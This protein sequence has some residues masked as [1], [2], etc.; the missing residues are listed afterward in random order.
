MVGS[1]VIVMVLSTPLV[2]QYWGPV[3]RL[4]DDVAGTA[5]AQ[6]RS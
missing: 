1:L 5:D 2:A 4:S 3:M 6:I